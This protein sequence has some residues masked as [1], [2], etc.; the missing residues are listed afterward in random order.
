MARVLKKTGNR[1]LS[2]VLFITCFFFCAN[3]AVYAAEKAFK[4]RFAQG[5][6]ADLAGA[7]FLPEKLD[8]YKSHKSQFSALFIGDSRT[9]CALHPDELEVYWDRQGFTLAHWANWMATQY[10]VLGDVVD[11][12][13][14]DTVIV[15]SIGADNFGLSP[16]ES[17]YPVG[18]KRAP[19]L[20][21]LGYP[22]GEVFSNVLSYLPFTFIVG[23][24]IRLFNF[25]QT[26]MDKPLARL[27][28]PAKE[29]THRDIVTKQDNQ[30]EIL[31]RFRTQSGVGYIRP[32]YGENGE[33]VSVAQYK[34]NGAALRTE[35]VPEYYRER[36]TLYNEGGIAQTVKFDHATLQ[37]FEKML[38]MMKERGLSVIVNEMELAPHRYESQ[39][40]HRK[41]QEILRAKIVP[42]VE[43]YGFDYV[44]VDYTKFTDEDYFD[45]NHMNAKG[46]KKFSADLGPKLKEILKKGDNAL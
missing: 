11:E 42:I 22:A 12:I 3:L 28:R 21:H 20:L 23:Q 39:E 4:Q 10:A 26:L 30:Q 25:S 35:L 41:T 16:I 40:D 14:Q 15:W 8:F 13:P 17:I 19:Y 7:G 44:H 45:Y 29:P 34:T 33:L 24:R 1:L 2:Y 46:V 18:L 37:L 5:K 32:W 6:A 43:S 27:M 38:S 9:L 31:S 36:Q